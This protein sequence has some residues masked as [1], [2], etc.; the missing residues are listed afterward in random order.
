MFWFERMN[1][2]LNSDI[3]FAIKKI[4]LAMII[5]GIIGIDRETKKRSA[6]FKTYSMVCIGAALVMLIGD[7]IYRY[8]DQTGDVARL[9]AQVI[10]GVGF[11]GVGTIVTSKNQKVNGLTTAA[12]LWTCACIGLAIGIGYTT[13]ALVAG[14]AVIILLKILK[15]VDKGI[16]K[17]SHFADIYL[18]LSDAKAINIITSIIE[19]IEGVHIVFLE[20]VPSKIGNNQIGLNL[21]LK[22]K[23]ELRSGD[24]LVQIESIKGVS[25][26][27]T[28]YT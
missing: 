11:L 5:G 8:Y 19:S 28:M 6:G 18:E 22:L 7:Y 17:R 23:K 24:I 16:R 13:G 15:F 20:S 12:G 14:A 3:I 27:H 21:I 2:V 25:F 1:V 9:G 4:V 26:V 10:S